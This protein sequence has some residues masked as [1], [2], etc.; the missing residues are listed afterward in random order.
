MVKETI[1]TLMNQEYYGL[2]T[3][4]KK[5]AEYVTQEREKVPYFSISEM[6]E[7]CNV[8][9]STISRFCQRLGCKGYSAFKLAVASANT[10]SQPESHVPSGAVVVGDD[11]ATICKKVQRN[12]LEAIRLTAELIQPENMS[13]AADLLL[14]A[15]RVLCMGQGASMILAHEVAHLLGAVLPVVYPV[16]DSHSQIIATTQLSSQDV[17]LYFSYSGA[18]RDVVDIL[19]QVKKR[20]AKVILMTRYPNSPAVAYADVMLQC[21]TKE[22]PLQSGSIGARIAQLFLMD[23]LYSEICRRDISASQEK[24]AMIAQALL[25][26]HL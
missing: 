26:K 8:A 19:S 25:E 20:G 1:F 9:E 15:P 11:I 4:E 17:V 14:M 5:L 2:T 21:G 12:E 6:A 23:V 13:K 18:T 24:S 10:E 7:A 16:W 3:A 22:S